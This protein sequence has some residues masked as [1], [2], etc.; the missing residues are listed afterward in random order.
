MMRLQ[1]HVSEFAVFG[2]DYDTP[3]GTAVR[4]FI[5]VSDL[6][7]AHVLAVQVL[8]NGHPSGAY[9][10]GTGFGYSVKEGLKAIAAERTRELPFDVREPRAGD[11]PSL[12]ANPTSPER[13]LRRKP[14]ESE[15]PTRTR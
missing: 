8:T 15:L 11:P 2:I 5:H 13:E 7:A 4:D 14:R 10:L 6:A 3:D 9:N 1:G 12:R